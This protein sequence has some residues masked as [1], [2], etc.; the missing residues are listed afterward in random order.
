M[1]VPILVVLATREKFENYCC[2]S[3]LQDPREEQFGKW[4]F[5][6]NYY[7]HHHRRHRHFYHSVSLKIVPSRLSLLQQIRH[8]LR[9]YV[10]KFH[11][12]EAQKR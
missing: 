4:S 12:V 9:L 3:I 8:N 1:F 2:L 10:K 11:W 5:L 7:H 6:I